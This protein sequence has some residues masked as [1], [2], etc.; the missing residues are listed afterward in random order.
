MARY[1]SKP[2]ERLRPLIAG[3]IC[4]ARCFAEMLRVGSHDVIEEIEVSALAT[5]D[6]PF[7]ET[8]QI[9]QGEMEDARVGEHLGPW[10]QARDHRIHDNNAFDAR[11]VIAGAGEGDH[12]AHVIANDDDILPANVFGCGEDDIGKNR[13]LGG[14]RRAFRI[15]NPR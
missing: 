14:G 9:V 5:A 4:G 11:V 3:R 7:R 2:D 8:R 6:Q 13:L 1:Q 12:P 10:I 15:A